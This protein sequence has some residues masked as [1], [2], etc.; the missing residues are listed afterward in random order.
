[1]DVVSELR[2]SS[3]LN[4]HIHISPSLKCACTP[5]T[6]FVKIQS[7]LVWL[8]RKHKKIKEITMENAKRTEPHLGAELNNGSLRLN[9][10]IL[11]YFS[12]VLLEPIP[13]KVQKNSIT[14]V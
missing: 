8:A 1:M 9:V 3:P 2:M 5:T 7:N 4:H 11:F 10:L 6:N 13:M 12:Q 14:H